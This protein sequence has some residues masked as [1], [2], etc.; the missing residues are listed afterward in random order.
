MTAY[1]ARAKRNGLGQSL[2]TPTTSGCAQLSLEVEIAVFF[3]FRQENLIS[4]IVALSYSSL[5]CHEASVGYHVA[6]IK[7]RE[8][9]CNTTTEGN[10]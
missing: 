2:Y 10:P 5:F 1:R 9:K 4:L 7:P 3:P 6:F 8:T